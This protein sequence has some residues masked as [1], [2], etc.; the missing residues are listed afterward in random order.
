MKMKF[1]Q[2]LMAISTVFLISCNTANNE[3]LDK[4]LNEISDTLITNFQGN[5]LF[6]SYL[7]LI[8]DK[9]ASFNGVG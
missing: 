2:F 4:Q 5:T 9:L 3:A 8:L 1:V 7:F 6:H